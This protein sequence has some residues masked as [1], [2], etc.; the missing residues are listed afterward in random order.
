MEFSRADEVRRK[1]MRCVNP[2]CRLAFLER[3]CRSLLSCPRT[4]ARFSGHLSIHLPRIIA[5]GC[6]LKT[7]RSQR[8]CG[9]QASRKLCRRCRARPASCCEGG[10]GNGPHV[11]HA[12]LCCR[13]REDRREEAVILTIGRWF[14]ARHS[15]NLRRRFDPALITSAAI[16]LKVFAQPGDRFSTGLRHGRR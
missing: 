13:A 9:S 14:H 4:S 8:Q 16:D 3:R 15:V 12:N 2:V 7:F 10:T 1:K 11:W 6:S 5:Y